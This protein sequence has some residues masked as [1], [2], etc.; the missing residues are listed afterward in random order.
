MG[1]KWL[2]LLLAAVMVF[3]LGLHAFAEETVE[4]EKEEIV[5]PPELIARIGYSAANAVAHGVDENEIVFYDHLTVGSTTAM[6][7]N[8]FTNLWGNATSDADVRNLL[9][10]Y[11][12]IRWDGENGMFTVDPSVVTGILVQ[13]DADGNRTYTF[14]INEDLRYSDGSAITAWDYAFSFLLRMSREAQEAGAVPMQSGYLVGSGDYVYGA[15]DLLSG[16]RVTDDYTI[17]ITLDSAYLPFFYEMGLLSCNP[18]PISVIAPGVTVYD[19][20]DGVYLENSAGRGGVPVYSGALLDRTLNDPVTGYRTHPSVVS[21]PY[22]LVSFDG[23]TAELKRNPYFHGTAYGEMP[24][25]ETL[26]YTLADNA[27]MMDLLADGTFDLLNKVTNVNSIT[28][29]ISKIAEGSARMANYPRNGLSFTVFAGEKPTVS[30]RNVR[31]AIA[32][33]M[34]RDAIVMDYTGNYGLR[35]DGFYGV[36]QWM[37]GV[38]NGTIAPPVEPPENEFDAEAMAEYEEELEAWEELTLE[39]LNDYALDVEEAKRLLDADGWAVGADGVREKRANNELVKLDLTILVADGNR[40]ADA[41]AEYWIPNLEEAGI[42]LTVKFAPL[43]EV[44]RNIYSK[45]NREAD[46]IYF[47]SNFD[48]IFDPSVFFATG[49]DLNWSYTNL[50]DREIYALAEEMRQTEPGEVLEYMQKWVAFQERFNEV[51]PMIPIYSNVYFDFYTDLLQDYV[52]TER[53]TWGEAIIGSVKA[54]IPEFEVEEAEEDEFAEDGEVVFTAKDVVITPKV[55]CVYVKTLFGTS[56][57][58]IN[59]HWGDIKH[60][61]GPKGGNVPDIRMEGSAKYL[62]IVDT[63][64]KNIEAISTSS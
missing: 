36:G 62:K 63:F 38:V 46:M 37:Y 5:V 48:T 53:T 51:L 10:G 57:K 54:E 19:D 1:R 3:S 6:A 61:E 47:A 29:G 16:V 17:A 12:L 14:T 4:E 31:Q 56:E 35:V 52:I 49:N 18:Y 9:H 20:G 24:L 50:P 42:N 64:L 8:F 23:T 26:T 59:L 43:A 30:S 15:Q 13:D 32:Y 2:A 41:F 28:E 25:I 45:E 33:C 27:T 44:S 21:G 7:G 60:T 55:S 22:T 34:D 58:R 39:N 40:I 11:N